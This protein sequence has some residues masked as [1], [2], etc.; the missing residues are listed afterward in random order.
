MTPSNDNHTHW[1]ASRW[2]TELSTLAIVMAGA[3]VICW[4]MAD[5]MGAK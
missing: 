5:L 4:T 3:W 2:F 1:T